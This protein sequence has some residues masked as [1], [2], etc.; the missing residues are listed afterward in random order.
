[1]RMH[2]SVGIGL[3]VLG[4]VVAVVCLLVGSTIVALKTHWGGERLR[5]FA[6]T[7]VNGTI[8]GHL[9][10]ARLSFGGDR[11]VVED[12]QLRDPDGRFVGSVA[13]A[14]V[15][16]AL[17]RV[18][19]KELRVTAIDVKTPALDIVS[20]PQG[21]NLARALSPRKKKPPEAPQPKTTKEGWVVRLD[22]FDLTGGTIRM[23]NG[24]ET[25]S[26]KV[27]LADLGVH[28]GA[29]YATGN[30][31]LDVNVGVDARSVEAPAGPLH[32][33]AETHVRGQQVRLSA[34][35]TMLGGTLVARADVNG[36]DLPNAKAHVAVDV[37]ATT[38]AG[39]TWGP[40]L[41][42]ADAAPGTVPRLALAVDVPGI[43]LRGD[44]GPPPGTAAGKQDVN[45]STGQI[46]AR[47]A[48][49]KAAAAKDAVF[50][51]KARL[52]ATD[53][54]VT[55]K[56]VRALTASELAPLDGRAT[57]DV[58]LGGPM[59]NAP[60]SWSGALNV[61]V[62]RLTTGETTIAGLAVKA[63]AD[64]LAR[65]PKDAMLALTITS[66]RSGKT[67]VRG[68]DVSGA[69]RDKD[70]SLAAKVAAPEVA[71]LTM[72]AR[73]DDYWQGMTV[74]RLDLTFPG[75]DWAMDSAALVG[76]GGDTLSLDDFS[77]SSQGQTL[78][79]E[80]RKEGRAISA[81]LALE[82]LRL[83]ALPALFVDPALRLAGELD[84]NVKASGTIEEP[85]VVAGL[86]LQRGRVKGFSKIDLKA[87]ATLAGT[88]VDGTLDVDAPFAALAARFGLP[89]NVAEDPEAPLDLRL[90]L[91]RLDLSQTLR[92]AGSP[93]RADGRLTLAL[94]ATGS[95]ANPR[96]DATLTG[97]ELQVNPAAGS[98]KTEAVDLGHMKL[99]VTYAAKD[100]KADLDFAA[101]HGGTLRVDAA[102]RVDLSYPRVTEGLVVAKLPVHGKVAAK[103][104]DVAWLAQL[105]DRVQTLAGRVDADAKLAGTVADPQFVGDVRWKNG[106]VIA[107]AAADAPA[108]GERANAP[109][110]APRQRRKTR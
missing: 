71:T 104:L 23:V 55:A 3:R 18:L 78:A 43:K 100:A 72:A 103:D 33:V 94:R 84:V 108:S 73:M 69:W 75:G 46:G 40:L 109:A 11:V 76:F 12:V 80:G 110:A 61:D 56:A 24:G 90:D 29:R 30:G 19:H 35:G 34:D 102:A 47:D 8:Q 101:S 16:V 41:V 21:S 62:P 52:D 10:I 63:H 28:A 98:T 89:T 106:K 107:N 91:S 44:G 92:A 65:D 32:L 22:R 86:H 81:H 45:G 48:N 6:V 5:R 13:R 25:T 67:N 31:N 37:P 14:E 38:L 82:H 88:R 77:L 66:V 9:D 99:R 27:Q 83:D 97:K 59:A 87:D 74:T 57:V 50:A 26:T 20:G 64:R 36:Q 60:A 2:R 51:F 54:A 42:H 70:I 95:L 93:A 58:T 1:M 39:E 15:D 53:L 49:D 85:R 4:A 105:S 96:V 17:M 79:I 7:R 68:I